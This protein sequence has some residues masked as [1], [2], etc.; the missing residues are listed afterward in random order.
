MEWDPR[1]QTNTEEILA[2]I[3][4]AENS[5]QSENW[6]A[7][8]N[9]AKELNLP[10]MFHS[11]IPFNS[12]TFE[13]LYSSIFKWANQNPNIS[14]PKLFAHSETHSIDQDELKLIQMITSFAN[15]IYPDPT[16]SPHLHFCHV[17]DVRCIDLIIQYKE[18]G[19]P[20]TYEVTPHH[21]LLNYDMR[22]S[23]PAFAKF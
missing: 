19:Y 15:N 10:I 8:F 5:I 11:E 20:F 3:T 17:T 6:R 18:K 12:P 4:N 21:L 23:I 1:T 7:L 14:N 13:E 22:F 2:E 9:Q 16:K